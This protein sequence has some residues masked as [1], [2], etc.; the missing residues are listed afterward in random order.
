VP[1]SLAGGVLATVSGI[2]G[3]VKVGLRKELMYDFANLA[4]QCHKIG[5]IIWRATSSAPE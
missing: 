5:L 2:L 3:I 4:F 1:L